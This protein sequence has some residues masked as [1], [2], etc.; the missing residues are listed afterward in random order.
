MKVMVV[1]FFRHSNLKNE[2][3]V[4]KFKGRIFIYIYVYMFIYSNKYSDKKNFL[5]ARR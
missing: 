3:F 2:Y 4:K 5:R 1:K